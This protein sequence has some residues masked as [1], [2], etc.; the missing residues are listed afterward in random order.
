[1]FWW[2]VLALVVVGTALAWWSSGKMPGRTGRAAIE[3]RNDDQAKGFA[4]RPDTF[5]DGN[6]GGGA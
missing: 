2:I 3:Y 4:Q 6:I 5:R 1:M